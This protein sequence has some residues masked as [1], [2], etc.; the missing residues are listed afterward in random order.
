MADKLLKFYDEVSKIGG[1]KARMRLAVLTNIPSSKAGAAP[2]SPE[3][4]QAF[5]RAIKEIKKEF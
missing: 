3:N 1:L 5:E 4:I 2:D